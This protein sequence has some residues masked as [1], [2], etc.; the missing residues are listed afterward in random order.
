MA[1]I[2]GAALIIAVLLV[3]A[4]VPGFAV[5]AIPDARVTITDASVSPTN[6]TAG[7]PTTVSATVRLSA[8]SDS[9]GTLERVAV[10]NETGATLAS[11]TGLGSLSPGETLTVP[12][13]VSFSDPGARDLTVVATVADADDDRATVRRPLSVAVEAGTPQLTT[14]AAGLTA[15]ADS[16]ATVTVSNPTGAPLR[17]ITVAFTDVAG[18]R[19]RQTV[20]TLPAGVSQPLN[21]SLAPATA[22]E[23]DLTVEASYTTAAGTRAT[24]TQTRA[25]SV[26]PLRDDV[27]LRVERVTA[28]QQ[29]AAADAGGVGG[30]AGAL[31]GGNTLQSD[32]EDAAGGQMGAVRVT[33]TNFGNAAIEEPV[34]VPR[35][36]N[37]TT[38][39]SV[40]RTAVAGTIAP[41]AT[42]SVTVDLSGAEAATLRLAVEY[43]IGGD[44]STVVRPYDLDRASG[45]VSVTGLS[46]SADDE[47]LELS[48][49]LGNV[50]D[51]EV[52]GVVV[53]VG[54]GEHAGPTYPNRDQFLGTVGPSEF[55]PF[56]LT[57]QIDPENVT[58]VPITVAYTTA[59]ERQ[60]TTVDVPVA[61]DDDGDGGRFLSGVEGT[62][63]GLGVGLLVT[64]PLVVF[65]ARRYQ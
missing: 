18:D 62:V 3:T 25:V 22:G 2:R 51:G 4:T 11:A 59:G 44:A 57:A 54:E 35:L 31:G 53:G 12:V 41:G 43:T 10:V 16:D 60:T 30:I 1:R 23:R 64:L 65:G 6:P 39:L 5:G 15:G 24:T 20:A 28:D 34:L 21:F 42:E 52:R 29:S 14:N 50:G 36:S 7:A 17:D 9:A 55:A 58:S 45:A 56:D 32:D 38:A 47:R 19:T 61:T 13:T 33:V 48:G 49:N 37:G 27:G 40:G 26:A 8:G 63:V 46:L